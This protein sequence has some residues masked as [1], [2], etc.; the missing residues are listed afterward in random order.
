MGGKRDAQT[1]SCKQPMFGGEQ[2]RAE[3]SLAALQW[4]SVVSWGSME[5]HEARNVNDLIAGLAPNW[6][7]LCTMY[8][9]RKLGGVNAVHLHSR[10][11]RMYL[12][13]KARWVFDSTNLARRSREA[14]EF[15]RETVL[16]LE[17]S[18]PNLPGFA[19]ILDG[20]T[21]G[22]VDFVRIGGAVDERI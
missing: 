9:D 8:V 13:T 2:P 18:D 15:C 12:G 19:P 10:L 1:D 22:I 16:F 4:L 20:E 14:F 5:A 7:L 3:R 21:H 17:K 11:N 6:L